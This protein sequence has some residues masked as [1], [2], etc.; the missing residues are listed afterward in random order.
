M[1]SVT[2]RADNV[3]LARR[4][5][6]RHEFSLRR[7][8]A[9][10]LQWKTF[11]VGIAILLVFILSA[12]F[13]PIVAPYDPAKPN[14]QAL[15]QPPSG[16]HLFGTDDKGRD[17]FSRVVYGTRISFT[18]AVVAVGIAAVIGIPLGLFA[19]FFGGWADAVTGRFIDAAVRVSGAADGHRDRHH[20]WDRLE[21][22]DHR[23]RSHRYPG[24]RPRLTVGDDR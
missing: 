7:L 8:L 22:S 20:H 4:E 2:A 10:A 13:A 6:A 21:G 1:G 18:I 17:I 16:D 24:V 12:I 9:N 5:R 19:G 15:L 14:Y 3:P 11:S 23:D